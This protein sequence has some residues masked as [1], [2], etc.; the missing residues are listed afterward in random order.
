[1][2]ETKKPS[3]CPQTERAVS[4]L[5]KAANAPGPNR[6]AYGILAVFATLFACKEETSATGNLP[7]PS[8]PTQGTTPAANTPQK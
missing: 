6:E 7:S 5:E 2:T 4:E 8:T 3:A 1:M